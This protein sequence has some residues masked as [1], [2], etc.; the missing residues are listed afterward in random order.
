MEEVILTVDM[1]SSSLKC[2]AY[3]I[4]HDDDHSER[5]DQNL[6][7]GAPQLKEHNE[8]T[9]QSQSSPV[10]PLVQA[11]PGAHASR[12]MRAV[13]PQTGHIEHLD[14]LLLAADEC[15]ESVLSSLQRQQQET[16]NNFIVVAVGF[17]SFSMNLVGLDDDGEPVSEVATISYACN[18]SEVVEEVERLKREMSEEEQRSL[19]QKTGAPMHSGYALAQLRVLY[20]TQPILCNRIHAWQSISNLLIARWTGQKQRLAS[21][22]F[23][24]SYS[25]ASW[26][27]LF[28]FRT[29][30]Y[31]E[32][33]LALLSTQCRASLPARLCD[34]D[35][36]SLTTGCWDPK[37]AAKW[38]SQLLSR[39]FFYLGLG[40][41]ACANIGSKCTVP[42]RI[43][44]TIGTSAAA[45]ICLPFPIIT[46]STNNDLQLPTSVP[47]AE[48]MDF[49]VPN[50]L[51]CYRIDRYHILLGGALTDGGSAIEW[52]RELLGLE[53]SIKFKECMEFV[54]ASI[55][56]QM[57]ATPSTPP[58]PLSTPLV[59]VPFLSGERST[60]YR[61]GATG[62]LFGLT[63]ETKAM[64]LV[65]SC[66]E[67]VT[68]R[69][70]AI[71]QRI[72]QVL[73]A[74]AK[75]TK[76]SQIIVSGKALEAN[77]V[78]RQ[79]ISNCTKLPVLLD[80]YTMDGTSRGV[81]I[82]IRSRLAAALSPTTRTT[83]PTATG[84][85]F[86][87]VHRIPLEAL[88]MADPTNH[89]DSG[90]EHHDHH[91]HTPQPGSDVYW[92][93]LED[94]QESVITAV[95]RLFYTSHHSVQT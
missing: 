71:V 48:T 73:D 11:I 56:K 89:V 25:E 29:G 51:F 34:F 59:T 93:K 64:D 66:L 95:S 9:L 35:D 12:A 7:E 86:A 81:A 43:A 57:E 42:Y 94:Q 41:G 28:N 24:L 67:G 13:C 44:C 70:R 84:D 50:G 46:H 76:G 61:G 49:H 31:E 37:Y 20:G 3:S 60:G 22:G 21:R 26:T 23:P 74:T 72:L 79:M 80:T 77:Y 87:V 17:S 58:V 53:E 38:P 40:D 32:S 30:T 36:E 10:M 88:C 15:L 6:D 2:S 69:L 85:S 83:T 5:R 68:L 16:S 65:Q 45:R 14:H 19:Y 18:T 8:D 33:A 55:G 75:T 91:Y 39:T 1:G 47:D 92:K 27:G 63:R 52:I 54:E 62:V 90:E 78:W 4:I 82:L